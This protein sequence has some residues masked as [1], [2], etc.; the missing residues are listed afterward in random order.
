LSFSYSFHDL[1]AIV[2]AH[3]LSKAVAMLPWPLLLN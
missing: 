2:V 1:S 3:N